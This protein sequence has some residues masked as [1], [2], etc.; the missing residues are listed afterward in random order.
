MTRPD[1]TVDAEP[2]THAWPIPAGR[3][4]ATALAW[5]DSFDGRTDLVV[6]PADGAAP[7]IVVTAD[8]GVG[9]G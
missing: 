7:P 3:R 4:P 6:A 9:G 2:V 8:C 5:V 1:H